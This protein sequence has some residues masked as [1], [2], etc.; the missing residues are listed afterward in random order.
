MNRVLIDTRV[1]DKTLRLI[2]EECKHLQSTIL[3][4][5]A[6]YLNAEV[7]L[8]N[9]W[10]CFH[11]NHTLSTEKIREMILEVLH[12]DTASSCQDLEELKQLDIRFLD[13]TENNLYFAFAQPQDS[14]GMP[15]AS[16]SS[17]HR[18]ENLDERMLLFRFG[19]DE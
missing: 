7:A 12:N 19:N 9:Q 16:H 6:Y 11:V 1:R 18:E 3:F 2:P 5:A 4:W 8:G 17:P 13:R 10:V 15:Y 14:T